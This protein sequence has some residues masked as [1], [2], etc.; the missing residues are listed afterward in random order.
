MSQLEFPKTT[1]EILE[2]NKKLKA[3]VNKLLDFINQ[4]DDKI[5]SLHD[6]ISVFNNGRY[7]D[8][9]P[10]TP[11]QIEGMRELACDHEE[12]SSEG[13]SYTYAKDGSKQ[14]TREYC[15]KCRRSRKR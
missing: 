13:Y 5:D 11:S 4:F 12:W 9:G 7:Y 2:D 3:A 8:N 14:Y 10:N 1:E 15:K 6:E